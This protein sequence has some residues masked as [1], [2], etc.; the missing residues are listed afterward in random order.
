M[1]AEKNFVWLIHLLFIAFIENSI[2]TFCECCEV[3]CKAISA[4]ML[5]TSIIGNY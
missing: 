3:D 4:L 5:D 2:F 1:G